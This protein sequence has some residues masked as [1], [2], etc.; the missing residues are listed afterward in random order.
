MPTA[1]DSLHPPCCHRTRPAA[2]APALLPPQVESRLKEVELAHEQKVEALRKEA[3]AAIAEA[4]AAATAATEAR[5]QASFDEAVAA[6]KQ[7]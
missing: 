6:E 4:A 5:L 2:T 7:A 3:E 1:H